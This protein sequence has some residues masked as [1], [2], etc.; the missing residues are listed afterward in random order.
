ML[1]TSRLTLRLLVAADAPALLDL[2]ITNR[3][4]L[5]PWSPRSVDSQYTLAAVE[6]DIAQKQQMINEDRGYGFGIFTRPEEA[7]IGRIN[8]SQIVRGAFRNCFLGYWLDANHNG[9]G[10]MSE[11]VPAVVRF[12]FDEL[13]LHRVEATTLTYNIGSQHVLTRAGFRHEG[14][15]LNY[16][17]I[18][19]RW[20]DHYRFAITAEEF[21]RHET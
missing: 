12:A 14:L 18:D 3:A 6:S 11:A 5:K 4:F 17:Q 7:L 21:G 1:T 15:A 19:G 9:Q 13:G 10:L 2:M 8:I 16:L 20:Q